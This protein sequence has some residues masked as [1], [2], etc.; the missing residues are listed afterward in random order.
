MNQIFEKEYIVVY[1]KKIPSINAGYLRLRNRV[2]LSP[3][4]KDIKDKILQDL[5]KLG[6]FE[7]FKPFHD[8]KDISIELELTYIFK[9][10]YTVRD[11]TNP[12]KFVEDAVS[13]AI[14][15]DDSRNKKVTI[16]KIKNDVDDDIYEAILIKIK[17]FD[18]YTD[19][20]SLLSR[21]V[22]GRES[23]D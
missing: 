3:E 10:R 7:D 1:N 21:P 13:K 5:I 23:R 19:Y 20:R 14:G 17:V 6:S 22:T 18:S 15:I 2:V 16:A 4:A 9:D 8:R 12:T 11:A